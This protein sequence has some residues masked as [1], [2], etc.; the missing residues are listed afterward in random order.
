[1][2]K[3]ISVLYILPTLFWRY[4]DILADCAYH[5]AHLISFLH[6]C[7]LINLLRNKEVLISINSSI[8]HLFAINDVVQAMLNLFVEIIEGFIL[9]GAGLNI[10][11]KL[12]TE[13]ALATV[14]W[15]V[16]VNWCRF[17]NIPFIGQFWNMVVNVAVV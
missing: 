6:F 2:Q 1:M 9:L 10:M 16:G 14:V 15:E 8:R 13:G 11:T 4:I 7:Y 5:N 3:S 12:L 17:S